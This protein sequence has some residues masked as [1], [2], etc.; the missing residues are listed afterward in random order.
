MISKRPKGIS[1]NLV[2]FLE[3]LQDYRIEHDGSM[4]VLSAERYWHSATGARGSP[5]GDRPLQCRVSR[6]DV[7]LER[8]QGTPTDPVPT[9][10]PIQIPKRRSRWA[11]NDVKQNGVALANDSLHCFDAA[12]E[13]EERR[14]VA[15]GKEDHST[16]SKDRRNTCPANAVVI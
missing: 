8:F 11:R 15:V 7:V 6:L 2:R 13:V 9:E 5:K 10:E 3:A 16:T 1:Q 12:G 14:L 4:V